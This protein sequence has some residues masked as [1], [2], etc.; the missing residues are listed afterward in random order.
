V[1]YNLPSQQEHEELLLSSN[2]AAT[3]KFDTLQSV[4]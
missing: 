4:T 1:Q 3:G 2:L